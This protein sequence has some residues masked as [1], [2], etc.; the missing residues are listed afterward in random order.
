MA[1]APTRRS[2]GSHLP[3]WAQAKPPAAR[4]RILVVRSAGT[5]PLRTYRAMTTRMTMNKGTGTMPIAHSI[6]RQEP[7]V[8]AS[9][10]SAAG[11]AAAAGAAGSLV[12]SVIVPL[13]LPV[14]LLAVGEQGE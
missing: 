4:I 12:A 13:P 5:S 9:A 8:P 1:G 11:G 2:P 6:A 10:A 14:L 7:R 3:T